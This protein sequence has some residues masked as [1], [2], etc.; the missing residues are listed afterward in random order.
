MFHEW[1]ALSVFILFSLAG[2]FLSFFGFAGTFV[3]VIAAFLY[4]I[5][6]WNFVIGWNTLALLFGLAILGELA[7]YGVNIIGMRIGGVSK[8]GLFGAMAGAIIGAIALSVFPIIG[9]I[10]GMFA[11]A[12]IGA[13]LLELAYTADPVKAFKAAKTAL[14]SKLAVHAVKIILTI[15]QVLIVV[16]IL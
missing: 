5:V 4:N 15:T 2:L 10:I 6:S 14:L 11:G 16:S 13:Y 3:V 8:H 1:I 12:I 9:T 7:E